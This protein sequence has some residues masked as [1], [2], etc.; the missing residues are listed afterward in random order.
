M[1]YYNQ[2]VIVNSRFYYRKMYNINGYNKESDKMT[3]T[4]QK[5]KNDCLILSTIEELVPQDVVNS[6]NLILK[7]VRNV[8]LEKKCTKSKK[9]Q[10]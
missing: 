8:H 6:I 5:Y 9:Y 7:S 4:R 1:P 3:M 10:K 2:K